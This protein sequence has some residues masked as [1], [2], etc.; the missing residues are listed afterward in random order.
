M[1]GMNNNAVCGWSEAMFSHSLY[2]ST[3]YLEATVVLIGSTWLISTV[4][5]FIYGE[6]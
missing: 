1:S 3:S 5:K 6:T 4:F 2:K